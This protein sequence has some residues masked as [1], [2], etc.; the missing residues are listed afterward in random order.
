MLTTLLR[1][2]AFDRLSR[3][4][5]RLLA[6]PAL[7]CSGCSPAIPSAQTRPGVNLWRETDAFVLETEIPGFRR[8]DVEILATADGVTLRGHRETSHPEGAT[9]LRVER[10]TTRFERT[11]RLPVEIDADA[12]D[13]SMQNGVLRVRLPFA[14]V[15]RPRRI[16]IGGP[17]PAESP[18]ALPDGG[19]SSK[20][21]K[22]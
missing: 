12:A 8:E 9:P 16:Q 5:D 21:S 15:A 11:F 3:E 20:P 13:A 17:T 6:A 4:M 10:M 22:S 18:K 7:A 1:D 19:E 14:A 2:S